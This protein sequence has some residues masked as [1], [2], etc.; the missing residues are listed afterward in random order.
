MS[1]SMPEI[2]EC[3]NCGG[4]SRR[5]RVTREKLHENHSMVESLQKA[6]RTTPYLSGV[7][8]TILAA[9]FLGAVKLFHCQRC[10]H[11]FKD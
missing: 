3:P 6:A 10:G 11:W 9:D 7:L 4:M 1:L 5:I 8:S 2:K